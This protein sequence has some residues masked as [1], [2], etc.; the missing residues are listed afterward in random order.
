MFSKEDESIVEYL[1][2]LLVVARNGEIINIVVVA[3]TKEDPEHEGFDP[4]NPTGT[5][6]T[7]IVR[8]GSSV[9]IIG[10]MELA[11]NILLHQTEMRS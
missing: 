1:E 2:K 5:I 8:G 7:A 4:L 9:K 6:V 3:E 10:S 11:Q